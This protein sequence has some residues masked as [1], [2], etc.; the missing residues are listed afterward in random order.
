MRYLSAL[1]VAVVACQSA[2]AQPTAKEL[3][4]TFR[5]TIGATVETSKSIPYL[6][7]YRGDRY[8]Y[9]VRDGKLLGES[10]SFD[11]KLYGFTDKRNMHRKEMEMKIG[12]VPFK[13]V[14]V[15]NGNSGWIQINEGEQVAMSKA[16]VDGRDQREIH[17]EV[18]LG[19][20]S[21][22]PKL[23]QFTEPKSSKVRGQDA[24][25]FE[26]KS[27]QNPEPLTLYF[28]KSSS[29]LLR[30]TSKAT[31]FAFLL[32][33]EAKPKLE[34]FTRDLYFRDWKKVGPRLLPG[35]LEA[36]H[37]GVLWQQMEPASVSLLDTVDT[38]LF[39]PLKKK[40]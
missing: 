6:I 20:E 36:Y 34:S 33:G 18:F 38:K 24:W 13:I 30:L 29:L 9:S 15:I 2:S 4:T 25:V 31:D 11:A 1:L 16:E 3:V 22:D 40:K 19:R 12:V 21:F 27:K 8:L 37:D 10:F 32:P 28:A 14:E 5:K 17:V 35:H 7:K 39:A 23:W 26:A